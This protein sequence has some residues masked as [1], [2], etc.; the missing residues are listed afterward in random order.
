VSSGAIIRPRVAS[1]QAGFSASARPGS[2]PPSPPPPP[3][4]RAR[5]PGSDARRDAAAEGVVGAGAH[6]LEHLREDRRG[7]AAD[8]Q[9]RRE[10]PH[11]DVAL[12]RI[13][14][15]LDPARVRVLL[16]QGRDPGHVHV[17]QQPAI[18]RRR[19]ARVEA[20]EAGAVARDAEMDRRILHH[21][22]PDLARQR[23]Q[24]RHGGGVAAEI[25]GEGHRVL[26]LHQRARDAR[27]RRGIGAGRAG[28][29]E[30]G[31][32][33]GEDLRVLDLLGQ[34]LARER[35]EDR[36]ARL[37]LHHRMAAG[38][39]LLRDDARGQAVLPVHIGPHEAADV[40][41]VLDEVDVVVPPA[42]Q[43]PARGEGRAAGHD[44]GR[45]PR[46]EQVVHR[47]R[48]IRRAGIDMH[49]HRLSAPGRC[50]IAAGHVDGDVLVR[51]E[52]DVR[53]RAALRVPARQ[54]LDDRDV[55]GAEVG[56]DVLDPELAEALEQ[57][58]RGGVARHRLSPP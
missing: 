58:V 1:A 18:R 55:V 39:R 49:Q 48:R 25:G 2:P 44:E 31:G 42:R 51:A 12:Q 45:Q 14:I 47:H 33:E 56:E 11:R 23:V 7:V 9:F 53:M 29:G 43:L 20:R 36:R 40:V 10:A 21:A 54:L 34:H 6:D 35:H 17:E 38:Q 16:H 19:G 8:A 28:G 5:A 57:V 27:G 30:A 52:H 46:A 41:G 37:G 15:H 32:R 13:N 4:R 26:G 3:A 24:H 22:H 50:G